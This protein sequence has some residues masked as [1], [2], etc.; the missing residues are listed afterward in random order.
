MKNGH[1]IHYMQYCD[2]K[3]RRNCPLLGYGTVNMMM[4]LTGS[5]CLQWLV[6]NM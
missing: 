4:S 6:N 5:C 1:F 2:M 3:T